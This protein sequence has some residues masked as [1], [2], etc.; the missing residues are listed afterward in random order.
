V[1]VAICDVCQ[2]MNPEIEVMV[3]IDGDWVH[4][5]LCS[6]DCV[7]QVL[8]SVF[9]QDV[10]DPDY[11][12]PVE[13]EQMPLFE[14]EP[15]KPRKEIS[16]LKISDVVSLSKAPSRSPQ[17]SVENERKYRKMAEEATS[18]ITGVKRR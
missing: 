13:E 14:V 17:E 15:P 16:Q 11:E 7:L 12:E 4:V 10:G 6:T 5:E 2:K 8:D 18:E 1:K 9:G 3:P